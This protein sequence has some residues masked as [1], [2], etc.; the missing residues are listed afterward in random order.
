MGCTGGAEV[1]SAKSLT[2]LALTVGVGAAVGDANTA[3]NLALGKPP[4]GMEESGIGGCVVAGVVV[5]A[6]VNMAKPSAGSLFNRA[7]ASKNIVVDVVVVTCTGV[8]ATTADD[9]KSPNSSFAPLFTSVLNALLDS[10]AEEVVDVATAA[11]TL[12]ELNTTRPTWL[13]TTKS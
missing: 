5:V 4:K 2:S 13:L 3:S 10:T 12:G 8:G 9:E 7:G 1:K 11:V 6:D